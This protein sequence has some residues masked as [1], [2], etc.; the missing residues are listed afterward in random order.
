MLRTMLSV[1]DSSPCAFPFVVPPKVGD[2]VGFWRNGPSHATIVGVRREA[3][4][5]GSGLLLVC[6]R[7][8]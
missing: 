8:I 3:A 7:S 6:A 4:P 1:D 2:R 5:D